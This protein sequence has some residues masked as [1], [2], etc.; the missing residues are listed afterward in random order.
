[1]NVL[2]RVLLQI[3][4]AGALALLAYLTY[5]HCLRLQIESDAP[6]QLAEVRAFLPNAARFERDAARMG[7][8][9]L[10][11]QSRRIGYAA[12]TLPLAREIKGYAG[13]TDTLIVFDSQWI[14]CGVAVRRS[15]DTFAH[16]DKVLGDPYFLASWKGKSWDQIASMDLKKEGVEGVSGATLTSMAV[17]RSLVHRLKSSTD[18]L[19]APQP[20]AFRAADAGLV[21]IVI[22]ALA[23]A[24]TRLRSSRF[25]R[26]V[27]QL[28]LIAG[29]GLLNGQMLALALFGGW[30]GGGLA[31]RSQPGIALLAAAAVLVPWVTRRAVYCQYICPHGAA[32]EWVH[33]LAPRVLRTQLPKGVE[34]GLRWTPFLLLL[35]AIGILLLALPQDLASLE[36]FDAYLWRTAGVATL[37]IAAVGLIASMFVPLAYCKFGCPTGAILEFIRARGPR[38]SFSKRD[39]AALVLAAWTVWISVDYERFVRWIAGL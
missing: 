15:P 34:A 29:L 6:V 2:R 26:A 11:G 33:R 37:A 35:A 36:P 28:V 13:P 25:L 23:L 14:V 3:Y 8:N 20:F 1:M 4:R 10:D 7:L 38:D 9:V 22:G 39:W 21:G 31:W 5:R 16:I 19:T 24:F 17:A 27:W 32:Q 18:A 12:R 30:A